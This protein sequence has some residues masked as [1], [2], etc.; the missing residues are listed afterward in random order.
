MATS[1]DEI[2]CLN[3]VIKNDPRLV[4]K[5]SYEVELI[6][7]K[8]L[9]F[10]ISKFMYDCKKDIATN[11][12]FS[13]TE[14]TFVGDGENSIFT[15][16]PIPTFDI[17]PNFSILIQKTCGKPYQSITDYIW[18]SENNTITLLDVPIKGSKIKIYAYQEGQ[19]NVDL[20]IDEKI[21]LADAMNI[22]YFEEAAAA[23]KVLDFSLYGGS[24]KMHSQA[25]H[26][27]TLED[28]LRSQILL[29]EGE[30]SN[31]SYRRANFCYPGL[32]AR[33]TCYTPQMCSQPTVKQ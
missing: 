29:V 16:S 32:G 26:Q 17:T 1:F 9:Q 23:R 14:Y 24:V 20:D 5:P 11:I 31:Y 8:Y 7:W 4:N 30:I 21:I 6:N 10:A 15:L 3:S 22:P 27:K 33:T 18:S 2:Y 12:P 13:S 19:F 28:S 25:E